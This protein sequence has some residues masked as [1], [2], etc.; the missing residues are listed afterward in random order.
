MEVL[1]AVIQEILS[2]DGALLSESED[3]ENDP[4]LKATK[5]SLSASPVAKDDIAPTIC[6]HHIDV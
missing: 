4:K 5:R 2:V 3:K 6:T 1:Q